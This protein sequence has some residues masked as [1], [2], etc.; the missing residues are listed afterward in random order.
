MALLAWPALDSSEHDEA[1]M[2]LP[3]RAAFDSS[4]DDETDVLAAEAADGLAL[5]LVGQPQ[6]QKT[7]RPRSL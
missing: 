6:Q 5:I 7:A 3:A 1:G 2:A 4:D